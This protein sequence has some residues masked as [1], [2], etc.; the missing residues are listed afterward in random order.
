MYHFIFINE[1]SI[2]TENKKA[3]QQENTPDNTKE[4]TEQ[5]GKSNQKPD[6]DLT[7]EINRPN[8]IPSI[9]SNN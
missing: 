8:D 6:V 5:Q 7:K 2:E 9:I 1:A 3:G 4:K